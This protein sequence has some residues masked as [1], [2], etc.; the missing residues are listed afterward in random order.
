[1]WLGGSH[2]TAVKSN[3]SFWV[4][5]ANYYG[6]LGDGTNTWRYNPVQL[7]Q[8]DTTPPVV[9]GV[10]NNGLYNKAR[11][12]TFDEG[13]ATLDG[14]LFINGG[15]VT[16]EGKHTLVVTDEGGNKTTVNFTIDTKGVVLTALSVS[17]RSVV[18]GDTVVINISLSEQPVGGITMTLGGAIN[19]ENYA[20]TE[21]AGSNG[22]RY[23]LQYTVKPGQSGVVKGY[24]NNMKDLAGNT[25]NAYSSNLFCMG[26]INPDVNGNTLIDVM[27]MA[28]LAQAYNSRIGDNAYNPGYDLNR[29]NII[30]LFDLILVSKNM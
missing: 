6:Q 24:M 30:D 19:N 3:S 21:V 20:M 12:I 2:T 29:D 9:S 28:L 4:W 16:G 17:S 25:T 18:A 14:I 7:L 22:L 27:D 26:Y 8:G 13:I 11:T 23:I 5:G 10:E 1:V 15:T